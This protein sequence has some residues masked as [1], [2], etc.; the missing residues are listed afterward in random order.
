[1]E[2]QSGTGYP[3]VHLVFPYLKWLA[4]I[5]WMT[6]QWGQ[7]ENSVDYKI[8]DSM[9]PVSYV[10]KY[11]SKLEGWSDLALSYLWVNRTRLYSMSRDY[12]LPDYSDKRVPEWSFHGVMS[13]YKLAVNLLS[14]M[15]RYETMFGAEDIVEM[16]IKDSS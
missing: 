13:H 15:S 2:V 9:S 10:C 16:V 11:I 6:E 8:K 7:A 5:A 3:H 14:I 4:P 1:M 12:V